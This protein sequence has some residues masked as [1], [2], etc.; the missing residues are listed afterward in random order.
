M[1]T[2]SCASLRIQYTNN[3]THSHT[4]EKVHT[5]TRL[6]HMEDSFQQHR[7]QTWKMTRER[8]FSKTPKR[9][10]INSGPFAAGI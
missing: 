5:Y 8:S 6:N 7:K 9:M 10:K 4:Q 1:P 2:Q 3:Y